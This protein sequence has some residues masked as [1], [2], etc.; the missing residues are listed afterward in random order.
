MCNWTSNT[1]HALYFSMYLP[2]KFRNLSML[3]TSSSMEEI[4]VLFW[5]PLGHLDYSIIITSMVPK[6]TTILSQNSI[7]GYIPTHSCILLDHPVLNLD[8]ALAFCTSAA[9]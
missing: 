5:Q 3:Q 7:S 1:K 2:E 8:H 9:H 6:W 4:V